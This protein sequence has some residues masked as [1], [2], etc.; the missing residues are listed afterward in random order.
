MAVAAVDL[1]PVEVGDGASLAVPE[2]TGESLL[3]GTGTGPIAMAGSTA[4]IDPDIS[5]AGAPRSGAEGGVAGSM[6]GSP[7]YAAPYCTATRSMLV[8]TVHC[9]R[10]ATQASLMRRGMS[11]AFT[12]HFSRVA[13]RH[14]YVLKCAQRDDLRSQCAGMCGIS[15][16]CCM[17]LIN[18]RT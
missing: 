18:L 9:N 2:V 10:Q 7:A 5:G 15:F 3:A 6:A 4:G 14:G 17:R 8:Q 12:K 11:D 16:A 13:T 1:A